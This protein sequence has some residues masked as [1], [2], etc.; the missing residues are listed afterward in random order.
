ML[1]DLRYAVRW[2]RRSPGFALVAVV[3]LGLGIGANTAMFSL[4]DAVLLRPIPVEDP[5]SLVDVFTTGGDGDEYATTSYPDFLDLK[6]QNAVFSDMTAYTMM[7]APLNLGDRARL[8][9]GHIVTSNHFDMLGVR[10][11]LGRMLQP[12]DDLPGAPPVV[13]ISHHL[14]RSDFGADAAAIGKTLRLRGTPY[15]IVGVAPPGFTG[16]IPL[17]RPELWLPVAHVEEIEPAGINDNI[18]SPTGRTRIERRGSRWLFVKGRLKP[19]VT[20]AAARANVALIGTQLTT[21][22]PQTNSD[23]RIHAFATSDVRLLVP[24]ASTPLAI[25]SAGVMAVVGLVLLIACANVAGMLLARASA[26]TREISVRLAIG[27]GRGHIVRQ[28]LSE[29][30]VL[31]ACGA[32]VAMAFAWSL[33]RLLLSVKLPLPAVVEIDVPLDVRVFVFVLAVAI[34][35]GLLAALTPALKASSMRLSAD[36]RGQIGGWRAGGR[37]WA[38]RDVLV[39]AQ[40]ALTMVLLVVAGLLLR[41]LIAAQAADVGLR[42]GGVAMLSTDTGMVRYSEERSAQFWNEALARVKALPGVDSAALVSPRLPFD[43]NY[44]TNSIRIDGKVYGPGELGE[45][46]A[47]VEVSPDYFRT[48]GI[49]IVEGRGF[50]DADRKGAPWVAVVN[51]TAARQFWPDG[52]VGRTFQLPFSN[53]QTVQVIGVA[54]DHRIFTVSERPAPYVHFAAAQRPVSYNFIVAHGNGDAQPLL[55]ALRRE[56]LAMEPGLVFIG[57]STMDSSVA[58]SLLPQRVAALLAM[59]FGVVGTL[60]AAIGLYGV[61]AFSVARRTREIGVRVAVGA[62]ARDVLSLILRQGLGLVAIGLGI[63][64]LLAVGAATALGGILYG[65]GA[66]DALAWGAAMVVM[67]AAALAANLVPARRAMRVNPVVALRTE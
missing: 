18:P 17:F 40:L 44:N 20:L 12:A 63:G 52:A 31:G 36:L 35:A 2:L 53:D 39:I 45:I 15:T 55:A 56:L 5:G 62:E 60:L 3:S 47:N 14:W 46:V 32:A 58:M 65:V 13:V 29:G 67:V 42:T 51:Q 28:M 48:L 23:R 6:A 24:Q 59:G 7:F 66:Y 54:R 1:T 57:S 19:G 16:V 11:F 10:P 27:A 33:I 8:T 50:N 49:D 9:M 37:H 61:I 4:I 43:V 25:G 22:Y 26:R 64:L 21:A 30:L 34:V 41:T 38:M